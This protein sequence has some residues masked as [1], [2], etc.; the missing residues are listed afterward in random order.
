MNFLEPL[1]LELGFTETDWERQV[2]LRI[3]RSEKVIPDYLLHVCRNP[4]TK[5]INASWVW[6][7]KLS[8]ST[9]EQLGKDFGQVSSYAKL[10]NAEGIGLISREGVW[11]SFRRDNYS[12]TKALYWPAS[13]LSERDRLNELRA[14]IGSAAFNMKKSANK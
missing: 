12:L 2:K 14:R 7:A 11:I 8:I 9:N 1:L 10:V 4:Q 3:G 6:E 5:T 13:Q